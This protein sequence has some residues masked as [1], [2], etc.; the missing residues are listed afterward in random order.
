VIAQVD[1]VQMEQ[2]LLNICRNAIESI[3]VGGTVT[4]FAGTREGR[5]LVTVEDTGPGI[6]A[7]DRPQ[8]LTPFFTTK[9][10]GQGLG[11]TL[12]H[13]I[14]TRRGLAHGLAGPPAGPTRFA[15]WFD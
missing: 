9:P 3:D 13:E 4:V 10:H 6:A 5:R 14:L 15:I 11:L 1:R 12:V 8:M 2:A 7:A